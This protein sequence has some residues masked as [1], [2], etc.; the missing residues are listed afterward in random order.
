M[1]ARTVGSGG[2]RRRGLAGKG[3]TPKAEDRVWH[4]AY[5][6][7]KTPRQTSKSQRATSVGRGAGADWVVGRNPVLEALHAR[8]P[9]KAIYV[10]QGSERD[11]RLRDIF[12][13]AA[14][15]SISLLQTTRLELDRLTGGAVHQG[16]ALQLPS[17]DYAHAD[18]LIADALHSDQPGLLIALDQITDPHNLG[19]IARSAA[20]FGAHGLIIP[21]RRSASVS[22]VAW[23]SSAGAL[24]RIRVGRTVNLNRTIS[25]AAKAGFTVVG[26]AAEGQTDISA[27]P[28]VDG[29]V[30]IVVGSEGNG[31]S[32]LTRERCDLLATIPISSDVESLNASVAAA[33]AC[34]EISRCRPQ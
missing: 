15:H 14:D 9:I 10:V 6:D 32:R 4:K 16:I 30:M 12:T 27:I 23:K 1:M 21:E 13:Y 28:G 17:Y 26:L 3:P 19:A 31:L 24:A 29:P 7:N 34:Y 22:A 8:L 25:D 18:D 20:A 11:N 5:R 33:I 2:K